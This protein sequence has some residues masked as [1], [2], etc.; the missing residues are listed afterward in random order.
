MC[1]IH[2]PTNLW[3]IHHIR[4]ACNT[5]DYIM[6]CSSRNLLGKNRKSRVPTY[7]NWEWERHTWSLYCRRGVCI[8]CIRQVVIY[9]VIDRPKRTKREHIIIYSQQSQQTIIIIIIVHIIIILTS[10]HI[11]Y[12]INVVHYSRNPQQFAHIRRASNHMDSSHV[13]AVHRSGHARISSPSTRL[14]FD[15]TS[16]QNRVIYNIM[17][18]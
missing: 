16:V 10:S 8:Q 5:Y 9:S 15:S 14:P 7:C 2:P 17:T 18:L 13:P 12:I 11:M 3:V 1:F 4:N 6:S